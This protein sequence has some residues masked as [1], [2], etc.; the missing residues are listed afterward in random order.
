MENEVQFINIIITWVYFLILLSIVIYNLYFSKA[1]RNG[2]E[3]S[4]LTS[5]REKYDIW[6]ISKDKNKLIETGVHVKLKI[7]QKKWKFQEDQAKE[8]VTFID[9]TNKFCYKIR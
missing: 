4:Y 6:M 1:A 7:E 2:K 5:L 8:L 9:N 3:L